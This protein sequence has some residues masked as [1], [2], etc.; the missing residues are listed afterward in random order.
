MAQSL[1]ERLR[2]RLTSAV[3][4][5]TEEMST[6]A[7]SGYLVKRLISEGTFRNSITPEGVVEGFEIK[8]K[9]RLGVAT[10]VGCTPLKVDGEIFDIDTILIIKNSE[11]LR[12]SDI[13]ETLPISVGY[14]DEMLI[15][16]EDSQG[17]PSGRHKMELGLKM[18]GLGHIA[19]SFD[20][21]LVGEG[22]NRVPKAPPPRTADTDFAEVMRKTI[23]SASEH[24]GAKSLAECSKTVSA[25]VLDLTDINEKYGV[26]LGP[27]GTAE[28]VAGGIDG[29]KVLTITTTRAAF[30][31]MAHNRL[32]PGIAYARGEIKLTGVP[33]LKLR[34]MDP[35]ITSIF[36]GYRAASSGL[37]FETGA[38]AAS[39]GMLEEILGITLTAF[40]EAIKILDGAL[41]TFGVKF[42]REKALN[43]LEWLWDIIDREMRKVFEFGAVRERSAEETEAASAAAET[44]KP[45]PPQGKSLQDK[46]RERISSTIGSAVS[47]ISK[48]AVS[49]YLVKRLILPGSFRNYGSESGLN[50]FEVKL[51]NKLGAA[52]VIGFSQLKI[53]GENF[54]LDGIEITKAR[55][56]FRAS[57]ISEKRPLP[58]AFG[59]E[60]LIRAERAGGIAPGKHAVNLGIEMVGLGVVDVNYEDVIS[61]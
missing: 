1:E 48:T 35:L 46:L 10:V 9:N 6:Q 30:H 17:L 7:F 36:Q 19:A 18:V 58:V 51:K 60:L 54:D 55:Q 32:N 38:G 57:D 4:Q 29:E 50:G 13:S 14:G 12:A 31:G 34:G 47:D 49:G 21:P 2:S 11:A 37:E 25:I 20:E 41:G 27:D 43:R 40:D 42:F 24:I 56:T 3:K 44:A 39:G 22:R 61:A 16:V 15:K 5:V 26:K 52:T 28:F 23:T 33:I 53:D 59:D 8:L 45:A